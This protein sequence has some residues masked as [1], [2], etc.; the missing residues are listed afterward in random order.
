MTDGAPGGRRRPRLLLVTSLYPTPDDPKAGVFVARR[1]AALRASGVTVSVVRP[2][3]YRR[4]LNRRLLRMTAQSLVRRGPFDGVEGHVLYPTGSIALVAARLRRVPVLLYAHGADVLEA[5]KAGRRHEFLAR[6]T[7]HHADAIVTNSQAMADAVAANLD[8]S[9]EVIPPGVDLERFRPLDRAAMR[10][11]LGLP[12]DARI[13]LYV[14]AFIERKGPDVFG[15]ALRRSAGW[16]GYAVGEGG[17][18]RLLVETGTVTCIS[19][20]SPDEIPKWLSAADVVVVPSRREPLGLAA[21]EALACG[22]PVI[23]SDTGGLRE[24]VR[25]GVNGLLVPAADVEALA[26]AL[27]RIA[28]DD[29][30]RALAARARDSVREHDMTAVTA[31]MAGVWRRLGVDLLP[32]AGLNPPGDAG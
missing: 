22:V 12:L 19:S 32:G 27:D 17:L 10:E 20:V 23:A 16:S 3:D 8:A 25:D 11:A 26:A 1:V 5:P 29:F 18:E 7:A 21:V 15:D 28:D 31:R 4:S 6:W 14:G 2:P 24:S 9:A 30:R 13:A